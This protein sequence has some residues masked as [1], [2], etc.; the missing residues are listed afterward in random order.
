MSETHKRILK[1]NPRP[2]PSPE[3]RK[4]ISEALRGEKSPR[5]GK[6]MGEAFRLKCSEAKKG[7]VFTPEHRENMSRA[8]KGRPVPWLPHGRIPGYTHSPETL[9]KLSEAAKKREAKK[10]STRSC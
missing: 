3:T 5:F 1:E 10:G 6:S 9:L 7:C 2:T 4:K 8:K